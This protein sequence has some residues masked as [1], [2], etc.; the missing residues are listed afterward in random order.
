MYGS[1]LKKGILSCFWVNEMAMVSIA[2]ASYTWKDKLLIW[3][4]GVFKC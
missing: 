2:L 4:C 1:S 3:M